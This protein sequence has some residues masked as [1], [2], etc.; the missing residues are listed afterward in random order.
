MS[1]LREKR[2][3]ATRKAILAAALTLFLRK[4]YHATA[5]RE[6]AE[7]AGIVPGAVYNHF[8]GKE[9]LY[10]ALLLDTN[11]Y[12]VLAEALSA[13]TGDSAEALLRDAAHRIVASLE[14]RSE[15]IPLVMVDVLEFEGRNVRHLA[16][17]TLPVMV[18]FFSA[19]TASGTQQGELRPMRPDVLG[20]AFLGLF[21]SYSITGRVFAPAA[22]DIPDLA[23][24]A[25]LVDQFLD[26]FA[27]GV[28]RQGHG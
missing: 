20:R 16:A 26:I 15:I 22:G 8:A 27:H 7:A 19:V 10:Q 17:Q 14:A 23:M 6:I 3:D 24:S 21:V 5:V 25:D 1:A 12:T 18:R 4:G 28:L 2:A 11:M 13:A 9:D